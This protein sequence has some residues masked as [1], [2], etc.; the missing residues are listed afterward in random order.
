MKLSKSLNERLRNEVRNYNKRLTRLEQAGVK[1]LPSHQ[2]VSEIKSRYTNVNDLVDEI[3]RLSRFNRSLTTKSNINPETKASEW[4]IDYIKTNQ[5]SA[6]EFYEKEYERVNKRV[7]RFAGERTYLDTLSAKIKLLEKNT[8]ALS[9]SELRSTIATINEFAENPTRLK[10]NYRGF[11]NEVDWVMDKLGYSS[12]ER[13][14]F[15]KKFNKLTPTQFLYAFDN[16]D[17]INRIYELYHKDYG[18]TEARLTASEE[19]AEVLI[20]ILLEQA[21]IIIKDAQANMV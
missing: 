3:E 13:D 16:N 20:N 14:A 21:D 19:D 17:I 15:F 12:E 8:E 2:K 5:K 1:N 10:S 6:K 18:E 9:P 11:L 4:Q 7:T